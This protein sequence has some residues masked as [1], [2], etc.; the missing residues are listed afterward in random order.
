MMILTSQ[1]TS[2][3]FGGEISDQMLRRVL[4]PSSHKV[5]DGSELV[6]YGDTLGRSKL[7]FLVHVMSSQ[8]PPTGEKHRK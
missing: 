3:Q 1:I 2:F 6:E 5:I 4:L 7:C 8:W